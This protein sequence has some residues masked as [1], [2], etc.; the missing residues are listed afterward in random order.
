MPKRVDLDAMLRSLVAREVRAVLAP[1]MGTLS[2]LQRLL[3]GHPGI[4][5]LRRALAKPRPPTRR[6][7]PKGAL[8]ERAGPSFAEPLPTAESKGSAEAARLPESEH[9]A[10][11]VPVTAASVY[12]RI[13]PVIRRKVEVTAAQEPPTANQPSP[14][15]R[16]TPFAEGEVVR[17]LDGG[18]LVDAEVLALATTAGVALVKRLR[19]G[20]KVEVKSTDLYSIR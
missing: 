12:E 7:K 9:A 3:D 5:D 11:A 15:R 10:A 14:S 1:H 16:S 8:F 18:E 19:D 17:V 2:R 13:K 6:R 4:A 20:Q